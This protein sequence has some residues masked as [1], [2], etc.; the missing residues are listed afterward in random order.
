M[1]QFDV[2][3]QCLPDPVTQPKHDSRIPQLQIYSVDTMMAFPPLVG[4]RTSI[5]KILF[6]ISRPGL[7]MNMVDMEDCFVVSWD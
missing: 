7:Q 2:Q 5:A 1:L 4:L 3:L 6:D